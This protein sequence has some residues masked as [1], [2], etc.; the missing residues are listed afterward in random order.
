MIMPQPSQKKLCSNS[1]LVRHYLMPMLPSLILATIAA[2]LLGIVAALLGMIVGPA[3]QIITA[4]TNQLFTMNE[5]LGPRLGLFAR[6]LTGIDRVSTATLLHNL[7]AMLLVLPAVKA[8]LSLAQWFTW[9]RAG[10]VVSREARADLVAGYLGIDSAR[11]K[12]DDAREKEAEL[13]STITT[14][15]RLLREYLVHFYGGLPREL[16]QIFFSAI[17][18][19]FLSPKLF[20]IFS[21]GILPAM[22]LASR[23]GKI[24]R[25]RAAKALQD[26][27]LLT[28]WL[29]QRLLG[30]ETIKHYKTEAIETAKMETLTASLFE[31][32]LRAARVKARTSPTMETMAVICMVIVLLVALQDIERGTTTGAVQMSF[33]STIAI[34]SGAVSKL[35]RYLNSNREGAAAVDR[36]RSMMIFLSNTQQSA[37]IDRSRRRVVI[38]PN[39]EN[40]AGN[41]KAM[42]I[43]EDLTASYAGKKEPALSDF[44]FTFEGGSIYCV[45]GPSGA[46]KSTLMNLL[47]GLIPAKAGSLVLKLGENSGESTDSE[48]AAISYMPQKVQLAFDTVA[49][50]VAYPATTINAEKVKDAL[51]K[52]DL[53]DA[54]T[55]MPDGIESIVGEGG[56]GLS[57]GQAQRILL[58]RL[59]YHR[60]PFV[61]VDEGTSALDPEVEGL[62]YNLLRD[63]ARQGAVI[64]TIAHRIAGA[65]A[66]DKVLLMNHGRLATSGSPTQ[67]LSSAEYLTVLG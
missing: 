57:G 19:I 53:L 25:R 8:V 36:L 1:A 41:A 28:E 24:I 27:S 47:L 15:V 61:L 14:D 32:F 54:V 16:A 60:R 34:M 29:Q 11:R 48:T 17:T 55:A 58:A 67:V 12:E 2:L 49:A 44:T 52:V 3:L 7:P 26:Y 20:M 31:R 66:A 43:C 51:R 35:G 21:L 13:S 33:F 10:E 42:I 64:I 65:L 5:L 30:I 62:V 23:L 37:S 56:A 63:L 6:E 38:S 46:G 18:L 4:P 45:C 59:Y 50:N 9:E 39:S 22:A 40:N